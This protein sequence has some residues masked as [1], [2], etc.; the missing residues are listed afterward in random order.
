MTDATSAQARP[1][2]LNIALWVVQIL[3]AVAFG[4]A[5]AM[6]LGQ[7]IDALAAAGMTYV[8]HTPE[9]LVRFIGISEVAGALGMIL[10]ALTRILPVL[11]PIA[12]LGFAIIQVLAIITHGLLGETAQTLP[13][14]LVLLALSL[15]VA[16]GR[17][18]ARPIAPR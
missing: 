18:R 5:G 10:P 9:W 7:P 6:K 16:W 8:N 11:T 3:L 1:R 17:W 15:F 14:N 12:A 13:I 4:A 2:W